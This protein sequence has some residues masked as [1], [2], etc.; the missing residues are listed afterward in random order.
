YCAPDRSTVPSDWWGTVGTWELDAVKWPGE[1]FRESVD[2][3]RAHGMKTLVWFE[4]ERVT[5]VDELVKNWG[6]QRE[7]AILPTLANNIGADECF[8]WT[9]GR[10]LA[11]FQRHDVD[12]YREDNNSD[13]CAAW[14]ELA[15]R[16]G[17][18]RQGIVEN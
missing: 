9:L 16:E 14:T 18:N 5:H 2:F 8:E 1:T 10:I 13:P 11:F 7:W 17:E 6:Y 15:A 4:P 12:M 3:A